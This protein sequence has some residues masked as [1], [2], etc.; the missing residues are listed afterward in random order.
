MITNNTANS[1]SFS[2]ATRIFKKD[3]YVGQAT[4]SAIRDTA[5][6]EYVGQLPKELIRDILKI[7]SSKEEQTHIIKTIMDTFGKC[8]DMLD[9]INQRDIGFW[10]K[11][12]LT[13]GFGTKPWILAQRKTKE[14]QSY[15][16]QSLSN[17]FKKFNLM[18]QNENIKVKE[19]GFGSFGKTFEIIFPE[20]TNYSTKVFKKFR[21]NNPNEASNI[22]TIH[23]ALA[24]N[25]IGIYV[26]NL[27]KKVEER[28]Q[29]VET[30]F[31]SLRR[32]FMLTEHANNYPPRKMNQRIKVFGR[33]CSFD[34]A[35]NGNVVNGRIVDYGGTTLN[36]RPVNIYTYTAPSPQK[37]VLP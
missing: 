15:M 4:L 24:E 28:E 21:L 36:C 11:I 33:F 16:S 31:G 25:N 5:N 19:L 7:S 26:T 35:N 20:S 6:S 10:E 29:F 2:G 1:P 30:H 13:F 3:I 37:R 32:N 14:F 34:M 22:S 8:S 18:G 12:K 9:Q 23:G 17:V 27:S